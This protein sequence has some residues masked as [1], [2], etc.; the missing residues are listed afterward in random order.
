VFMIS[1]LTF[2]KSPKRMSTE[3]KSN[4]WEVYEISESRA[5]VVANSAGRFLAHITS[6]I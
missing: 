1:L 3:A 5:L 2:R 4:L 6:P